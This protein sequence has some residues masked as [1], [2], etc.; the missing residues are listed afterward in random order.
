M[1]L[2]RNATGSEEKSGKS[3]TK[4]KGTKIYEGTITH[5]TIGRLTQ[6]RVQLGN[7]RTAMQIKVDDLIDLVVPK[8]AFSNLGLDQMPVP[9]TDKCPNDDWWRC[10]QLEMVR[11][12]HGYYE[13]IREGQSELFETSKMR[14]DRLTRGC[15]DNFYSTHIPTRHAQ[16]YVLMTRIEQA[17]M[18]RLRDEERA[19][20]DTRISEK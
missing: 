16:G 8:F 18:R 6:I 15:I 9:F 20:R 5:E 11:L 17:D 3:N 19:A 1:T 12:M 13:A 7:S 2:R 14:I 10:L 4:S